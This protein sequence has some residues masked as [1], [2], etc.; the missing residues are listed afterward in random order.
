MT[1]TDGP[2]TGKD[3]RSMIS[4]ILYC[5]EWNQNSTKD[6]RFSGYIA[7][8]RMAVTPATEVNAYAYTEAYLGSLS[9][10]SQR[11]GARR[12]AGIC[13]ATPR[14]AAAQG[15]TDGE[16]DSHAPRLGASLRQLYR[17]ETDQWPATFESD[18]TPRQ[19][20]LLNQVNSLPLLNVEQAAAL[21]FALIKRCE[22]ANVRVDFHD[23][24][25]TLIYWGNGMSESS[26]QQRQRILRDFYYIPVTAAQ[27]TK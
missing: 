12:A 21:L 22:D 4:R 23:L 6:N 20:A 18:G 1:D 3:W 11:V 2:P 10:E 9:S 16:P 24:A 17:H 26:R 5:R 7:S 15:S 14:V 19:N 8:L 13:A 27:P 25:R